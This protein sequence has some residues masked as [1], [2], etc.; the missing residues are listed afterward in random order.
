VVAFHVPASFQAFLVVGSSQVDRLAFLVAGPYLVL[1]DPT[2]EVLVVE[3]EAELQQQ[4]PH[5]DPEPSSVVT[6]LPHLS[7][8]LGDPQERIL[9]A[10]ER[11]LSQQLCPNPALE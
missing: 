10:K 11:F 3:A 7:Q 5:R 4:G 6:V 2:L 8:D 9:Q 1:A